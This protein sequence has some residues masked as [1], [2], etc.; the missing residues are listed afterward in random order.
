MYYRR[1]S[2]LREAT[3][4]TSHAIR[5]ERSRTIS[6]TLTCGSAK[7]QRFS[8]FQ[9]A[10]AQQNSSSAMRLFRSKPAARW[11]GSQQKFNV[12]ILCAV[13]PTKVQTLNVHLER[14]RQTSSTSLARSHVPRA[15]DREPWAWACSM[16][17]C[18]VVVA[19]GWRQ[20]NRD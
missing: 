6:L 12:S 20:K 4:S 16:A 17:S 10:E 7:F 3:S 11:R 13:P 8:S 18:E 1:A 2:Q 19:C 14:G 5:L 15:N 9:S